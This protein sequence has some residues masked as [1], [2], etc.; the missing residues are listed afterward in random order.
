[1]L[2][3]SSS[4]N[5]KDILII[6]LSFNCIKLDILLPI[7]T[8]LID[9]IIQI[10]NVYDIMLKEKILSHKAEIAIDIISHMPSFI[11]MFV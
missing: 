1:L 9:D 2:R 5:M 8:I 11:L 7:H 3:D 10:E 4:V 6:I